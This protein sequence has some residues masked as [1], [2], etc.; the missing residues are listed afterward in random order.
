M[1]KSGFSPLTESFEK[2]PSQ[3]LSDLVGSL[4]AKLPVE[5][6]AQSKGHRTRSFTLARTFWLFLYL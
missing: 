3:S 1:T 2:L 5:E 4:G 6:I